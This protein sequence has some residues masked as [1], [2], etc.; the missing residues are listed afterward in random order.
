MAQERGYQHGYADINPGMYDADG[1]RRKAETMVAVLREQLGDALGRARVLNLG[2]SAG[3]ID[4]VIAPHVGSTV[5]VDIDAK[6]VAAAIAR[7][8]PPN[9]RFM[10]G[11]A[12]AL[13]LQN[14][15]FEVVICSQVY[16]HVP[17]PARMMSEIAR[18]LVPGGLCYFAATSRWSVV[19]MH[20]K[21]PF[22]SWL[23]PRFADAY[24]RL[25]GRGTRYYERHLGVAGLRRLVA[26]FEVQDM[27]PRILDEPTRYG[28][29]YM[30]RSRIALRG[31]RWLLRHAYGLFPGFVWILRKPERRG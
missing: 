29:D 4:E 31:A 19:E 11:D 24:L 16:E 23:P 13:A 25:S 3:L 5:G 21:L 10:V 17:D 30:F 12:M 28:A 15:S 22:L 20:Y 6:A 14:A 1:R 8:A 9:G 7:G 26:A 27:T 2:C 18:V